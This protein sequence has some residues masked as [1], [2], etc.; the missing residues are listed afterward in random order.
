MVSLNRR[1]N[2]VFILLVALPLLLVCLSLSLFYMNALIDTVQGQANGLLEQVAQN[3]DKELTNVSVLTATLRYD[4]ELNAAAEARG[5]SRTSPERIAAAQRM[6]VRLNDIFTF[7]NRMGLIAVYMRDGTVLQS[8]NYPNLQLPILGDQAAYRGARSQPDQVVIIDSLSGMAPQGERFILSA[9]ICPGDGAD[10]GIE[11]IM[12][13]FRISYLD[14]LTVPPRQDE[15]AGLILLGRDR[16]AILSDFTGRLDANDRER[17]RRLPPG[18]AELRLQG[19]S[20]LVNSRQLEPAG[21]TLLLAVDKAGITKRIMDYQW[22]L[23][24]ALALM[25]GLFLVYAMVFFARVSRPIHGVVEN[26]RRFA[27]GQDTLPVRAEGISELVALT[28][29]FESMETEIRR[30]DAERESQSQRRLAAEIRALQFQ[31]NPHFVANTLNSIRMMALA[32]RN[33]AIRDM[34]QALIR[35]LADSYA[36]AD[37]MTNLASEAENLKSYLAIMKVRFAEHFRTEWRIDDDCLDCHVLRM[38]LQPL[39]ENAILHGFAGLPRQGLL[40]ITARREARADGSAELLLVE[41]R[42]NGL[43]MEEAKRRSLLA[44]A[45]QPAGNGSGGLAE[46]SNHIG[47]RN[48]H[49]RI[50]LHFGADYGLEIASAAGEGTTVRLRLPVQREEHPCMSS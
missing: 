20:F 1:F 49:E 45:A 30:L 35:I 8:S 4:K 44:E 24:P 40:E 22:Y 10:S 50:R 28:R 48:V 41:I 9:L 2:M 13:M 33:D 19:K 39:V 27:A 11:A 7:T 43:G 38:C 3:V 34:T 6:S 47:V 32:A 16:G 12:V 42:D 23:Y 17:I 21:W 29:N 36:S 18:G 25:T 37:P 5:Q 26:M 31:I 46:V 14:Q 15:S